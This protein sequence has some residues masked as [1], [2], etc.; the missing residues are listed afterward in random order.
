MIQNLTKK[1]INNA[2]YDLA[3]EE[4]LRRQ[5]GHKDIK[6]TYTFYLKVASLVLAIK[7]KTFDFCISSDEFWGD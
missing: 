7:D 6:T 5:I 3:V 1:Q 2:Y 4:A